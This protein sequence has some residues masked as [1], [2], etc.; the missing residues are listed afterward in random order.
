M[1]SSAEAVNSH[2]LARNAFAIG[3]R[4]LVV[5]GTNPFDIRP[6]YSFRRGSIHG[7]LTAVPGTERHAP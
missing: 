7:M 2:S 3:I 5:L 4:P 6:L 1:R